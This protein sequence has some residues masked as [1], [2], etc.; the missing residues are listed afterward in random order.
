MNS[1]MISKVSLILLLLSSAACTRGGLLDNSASTEAESA[2]TEDPSGDS[3]GLSGSDQADIAIQRVSPVEG[4]VTGGTRI[5][6]YGEGF[7]TNNTTVRVGGKPCRSL[8]YVSSRELNCVTPSGDVGAVDVE[9]FNIPLSRGT[10]VKLHDKLSLAF[11]YFL[12]NGG[13]LVP[14]VGFSAGGGT[15]TGTGL[16]LQATLGEALS[17]ARREGSGFLLK[18]GVEEANS[19]VNAQ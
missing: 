7:R 4:I 17:G 10:S 3:S 6:V 16:K 13:A 5:S 11:T 18:A 19:T 1:K 8:V 15:S 9:V 12:P 2:A 14:I